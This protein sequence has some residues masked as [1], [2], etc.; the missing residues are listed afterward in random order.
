MKISNQTISIFTGAFNSKTGELTPS[1]YAIPNN[2]LDVEYFE[3]ACQYYANM[4][5]AEKLENKLNK[6][7]TKHV[8]NGDIINEEELEEYTTLETWKKHIEEYKT[9]VLEVFEDSIFDEFLSDG[10]ARVFTI[11]LLGV[12]SYNGL[13]FTFNEG[14]L[15]M[16]QICVKIKEIDFCKAM[17]TEYKKALL[18]D[19]KEF[20]GA[21]FATHGGDIYKNISYSKFTIDLLQRE[22]LTRCKKALKHNKKGR[23]IESSYLDDFSM[24]MQLFALCMHTQGIPLATENK[25]Q[26]TFN[27]SVGDTNNLKAVRRKK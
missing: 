12:K 17:T 23:G 20:C 18:A 27:A 5:I 9:Q 4:F 7:I 10:F 16:S 2:V 8:E 22:L 15:D 21:N 3:Y 1:V 26:V 6:T 19:I 14:K 11:S 13:D 25:V 24:T